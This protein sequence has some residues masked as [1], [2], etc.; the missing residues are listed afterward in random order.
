MSHYAL[1]RNN[2]PDYCQD[3]EEEAV[4]A[5]LLHLQD[6]DQEVEVVLVRGEVAVVALI[7]GELEEEQER[8]LAV[9][10]VQK[11]GHEGLFLDMYIK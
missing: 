11:T 5:L 9:R 4:L 6:Q 2:Y 3:L 7:L 1:S 8:G 10:G